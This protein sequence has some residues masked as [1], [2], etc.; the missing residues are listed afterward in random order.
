MFT[1]ILTAV[2]PIVEDGRGKVSELFGFMINVFI[3]DI[4][5]RD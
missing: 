2:S 3:I 5:F 4:R 1:A